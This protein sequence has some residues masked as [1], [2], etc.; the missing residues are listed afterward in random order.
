MNDS[1][2]RE[3]IETNWRRPLTED[4]QSRLR[5]WLAA[6]SEAH[7][8]WEAESTLNQTLARL[9]DVPVSS[10]FTA[11][12]MQAV[13]R[14][15]AHSAREVSFLDR[16]REI[17][18]LRGPRVAWSLILVGAVWLGVRQHEKAARHELAQGLAA[19]VTFAAQPDPAT[20]QDMG[21]I[22]HLSQLPAQGDDELFKVLSQ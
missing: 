3:L 8:D 6:H 1:E 16:I 19:L 20:L 10:N 13:D 15:S 22:Q 12:V 7:A 5:G 17:F 11:L 9:P 2:Y 14:E 21:A 4:E 18:R